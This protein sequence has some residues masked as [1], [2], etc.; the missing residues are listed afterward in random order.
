MIRFAHLADVHLG[1]TGSASLVFR[2]DE[3]YAG[4][5]VREVDI[6][7]AARNLT[8]RIAAL[9]NAIDVVLI[10]G[11][12]FH[13]SHPRP[14]AIE[15]ATSMVR[16]FVDAGIDVVIIDGNHEISSWRH[17]GSPTSFLRALGAH[18]INGREP[19]VLRGDAW[20]NV[21]LR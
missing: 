16:K 11:D 19:E 2:E 17:T 3:E 8:E 18:V 6:E 13:W 10:A 20:R 21:K 15:A 5:Y 9:S 12:L 14:R 4:R 7:C 1:Y